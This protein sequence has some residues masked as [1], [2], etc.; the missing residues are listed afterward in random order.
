ML[1]RRLLLLMCFTMSL[2][3]MSHQVKVQPIEIKLDVT[4][5]PADDV[6]EDGAD[7]GRRERPK[8]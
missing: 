3:C 2:G 8:R 4:M 7:A 5:H 1:M 6:P